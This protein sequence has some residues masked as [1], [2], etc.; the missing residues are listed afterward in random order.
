MVPIVA[1][2]LIG[3]GVKLGIGLAATAAKKLMEPAAAS[4][5]EGSFSSFLNS[6]RPTASALARGVDYPSAAVHS[7]ARLPHDLLGRLAAEHLH[8]LALY[9]EAQRGVPGPGLGAPYP[10]KDPLA[11]YRRLDQA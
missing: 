6:D 7:P 9:A 5:A 1:S 11:A 10:A 8:G 4:P 3:V 2:L